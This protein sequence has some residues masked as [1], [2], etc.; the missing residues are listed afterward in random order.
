MAQITRITN[1]TKFETGDVPTQTDFID[2]IDSV[3]MFQSDTLEDIPQGTNRT[4]TRNRG[5]VRIAK[6]V[7]RE[8][9]FKNT[10][11]FIRY[12]HFGF[13]GHSIE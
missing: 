9:K 7:K 5:H 2:L 13:G 10:G 6:R 12:G 11:V 1:K 8:T 4:P 3:F